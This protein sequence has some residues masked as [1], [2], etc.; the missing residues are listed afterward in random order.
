[1]LEWQKILCPVDFSSTSRRALNA[2]A[3]LAQMHGAEL[4]LLHVY[5]APGVS[6]PEATIY[7]GDD[8]LQQLVDMVVKSLSEWKVEAERK[9]A[10][11]VVTHTAMGVP[12]A[13]ILRFAERHEVDLIVMGTHG[14]TALMRVLIGSVAEK[15][16]RHAPCPVLTV[17]PEKVQAEVSETLRSQAPEP[18]PS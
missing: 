2:A 10:L 1:M 14:R 7:A 18:A 3:E 17:R 11:N 15:V 6:F 9:G 13:E 16:V 12:F 4:H 5:Q 8:V